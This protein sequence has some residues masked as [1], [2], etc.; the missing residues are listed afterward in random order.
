LRPQ[1]GHA[2]NGDFV[3]A[4]HPHVFTQFGEVLHQ[5]VGEAVVV[6]DH[7][8]HVFASVCIAKTRPCGTLAP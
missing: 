8:Q 1:F 6:V 3:V 4:K 2:F 7:Q 5:V